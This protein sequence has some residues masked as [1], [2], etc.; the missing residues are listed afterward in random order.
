MASNA[1]STFRYLKD[2]GGTQLNAV[3]KTATFSSETL[4]LGW[5]DYM[6]L[7]IETTSSGGTSPTLNIK[8]QIS[9][10]GGT[11]WF[12]VYPTDS[13]KEST[14]ADTTN[15]AVISEFTGDAAK[16]KVWPVWAHGGDGGSVL[17]SDTPLKPRVK[18]VFTVTGTSPTFTI[19]AILVA[20]KYAG[21]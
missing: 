14:S 5:Y 4:D 11:N 8:V 20:R 21:K 6:G 9:E 16:M 19:A 18:F 3:A 10:D 15:Q 17:G 13:D 2:S 12:D 1:L 7:I